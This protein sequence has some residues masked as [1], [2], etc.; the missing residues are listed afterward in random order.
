MLHLPLIAAQ[1]LLGQFKHEAVITILVSGFL[2][3]VSYPLRR[4]KKEW[5]ALVNKLDGVHNELT[6]QRSNC[7]ATLQHQG[8]AQIELLSKAVETLTDIR[9]DNREMMTHLRDKL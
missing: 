6:V 4:A 3:V 5:F 2:T 9:L 7:L 8:T 1:S